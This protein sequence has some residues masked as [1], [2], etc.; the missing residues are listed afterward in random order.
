MI[1]DEVLKMQMG[2]LAVESFEIGKVGRD[3]QHY[4]SNMS[5]KEKAGALNKL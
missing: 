5:S 2:L 3:C 4:N 1:K